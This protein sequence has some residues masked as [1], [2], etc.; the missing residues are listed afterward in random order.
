MGIAWVTTY[1]EVEILEVEKAKKQ[2]IEDRIKELTFKVLIV[3]YNSHFYL[4]NDAERFVAASELGIS[5]NLIQYDADDYINANEFDFIPNEAFKF[6]DDG[7]INIGKFFEWYKWEGETY[8]VVIND[9]EV[10]NSN[11]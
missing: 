7:L 4:I 11:N 9:I 1:E 8:E 5:I 3:G 6:I 10:F 2:L